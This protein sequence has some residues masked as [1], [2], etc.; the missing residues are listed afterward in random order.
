[1]TFK[2]KVIQCHL[3]IIYAKY[4]LMHG[5]SGGRGP[6]TFKAKVKVTQGQLSTIYANASGLH[7]ECR[8]MDP[9]TLMVNVKVIEDKVIED[10][11]STM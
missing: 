1:M 6:M 8:G 7:G 11:M 2:V 5:E 4:L 9:M 3:L 10:Q